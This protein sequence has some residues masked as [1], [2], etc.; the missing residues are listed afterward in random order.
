MSLGV[1]ER[2]E[3]GAGERAARVDAERA[4]DG[5][6]DERVVAGH[7]LDRDPELGESGDGRGGRRLRLVEEHEEAGEGQVVLVVGRRRA[8]SSGATRVATAT[9]RLP[10]ANSPVEHS[11]RVVGDVGAALQHPPPV[12]PW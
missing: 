10:A 5:L 1:V 9:T 8:V 12:R 7:D 2:V 3:V 6:G 4:A 11:A